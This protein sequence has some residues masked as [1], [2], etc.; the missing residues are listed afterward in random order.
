MTETLNIIGI[1]L[2]ASSLLV[3]VAFRVRPERPSQT[4]RA[5][6]RRDVQQRVS[7][8]T[9]QQL[10]ID[11]M[12]YR[13][14]PRERIVALTNKHGWHYVGDEISGRSWFLDFNKDPHAAVRSAQENDPSKRLASE[15]AAATPDA[16]GRYVLDTSK[17]AE[18]SST[19]IEQIVTSAG[20]QTVRTSH[21]DMQVL[22]RPGTTT[23][24]FEA[25]PFLDGESPETL[26]S[27][28]AVL[29]RAR[30]IER[31]KGFDPLSE[32]EL[33]RAQKRNEYWSKPFSRQVR[34]AFF[35]AVIGLSML[36]ITLSGGIPDD[37]PA[38]WV[39]P[40]MTVV[41]FA[42]LAIAVAKA[43]LVRK[44]RS[45]EIGDVIAAYQELQKIYRQRHSE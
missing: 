5:K 20:W 36:G 7:N 6:H 1:V 4:T 37:H 10:R 22:A 31:V 33:N 19:T 8:A 34:L 13:G 23:A 16:K 25:G 9:G 32:H 42:L 41:V 43:R 2:F 18:L 38:K 21:N 39:M 40:A 45:S 14:V 28:A 35:Y 11:W 30:E 12:R 26:R 24:E 3:L 29:D 15:L 17:Y 27:D 44:K